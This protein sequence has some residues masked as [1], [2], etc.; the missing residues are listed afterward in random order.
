ML[1]QLKHPG[2]I[3]LLNVYEAKD[4]IHLVFEYI[5][6]TQIFSVLKE[7][8]NYSEVDAM[9]IMKSLLQ[10]LFHMHLN[11]IIYR[12]I[13]PENILL[14]YSYSIYWNSKGNSGLSV[15][16]INLGLSKKVE[17]AKLEKACCGSPGHIAPEVINKE[18]YG[19]KAD[20][21]SCGIILY[22][23]YDVS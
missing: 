12:D 16:I 23:L 22:T 3:Q 13:K 5:K 1:R 14:T 15:K 21:Y 6:D 18:G 11:Q 10:I 2:V 8:S 17:G 19:K 4:Y 7:K 20:V 9:K